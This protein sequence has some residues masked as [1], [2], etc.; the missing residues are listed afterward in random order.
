MSAVRSVGLGEQLAQILRFAI[1]RGEMA[2]GLHLVE[3]AISRQYDVSRG[4]VRD[5]LRILAA[6]GLVE[7]RRRG[8]YVKAFTSGDVH[9]LYEI[10]AAAER[11]ACCLAIERSVDTDWDTAAAILDEMWGAAKVGDKPRYATLDLSFHTEFFVNSRNDRLLTLWHQFQ[12]TFAAL[13]DVSN[14][15]DH[16]LHPSAEDH[17]ALLR[18]CRNREAERLQL[19]LDR[20]LEGSRRSMLI[21]VASR[22]SQR[23][24]GKA[25]RVSGR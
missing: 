20:H 7:S 8:Y 23:P 25:P 17:S 15:Q 16:D 18:H 24:S 13:L 5:A 10:R 4:P 6:E 1:I 21:A 2:P 12:P 11:L 14:A 22:E 9:Q 19:S 3:G